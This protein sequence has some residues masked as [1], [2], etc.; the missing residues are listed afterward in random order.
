CDA[1]WSHAPDVVCL[2]LDDVHEIPMGSSGAELLARLITDLP[3]N[4][5]IVL[6][7]RASVPLPTARLAAN[8]QLVRIDEKELAF[9]DAELAAFASARGIDAALLASASGW[10]ALAELTASAGADLVLPYLW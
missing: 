10:P 1:V 4:G 8:G 5:H 3:G 7:S 2:V 6:A 9:D